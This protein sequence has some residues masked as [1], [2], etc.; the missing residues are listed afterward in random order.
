VSQILS[1]ERVVEEG[2]RLI[3]A[4][5]V[6]QAPRLMSA[7]VALC[8]H[9][10]SICSIAGIVFCLALSFACSTALAAEPKR[11]MMLHSFGPDVKPWSEYARA[12]RA[13]LAEQ[14]PWPLDLYEHS[15]VSAR[16]SDEDPEVPFV[17]Y[18]RALYAKRPLDLIVTIGA[19]AAAFVQRHRRQLFSTAPMVFTARTIVEA[20]AGKIW[21]ENQVGGGAIFRLQLPLAKA[22]SADA[23]P[24]ATA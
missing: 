17:E 23:T 13:E 8:L 16:F 22:P 5:S 14:S 19:P 10:R 4:D 21:A 20:H 24:P 6:A 9:I 15:L 12:I 7:I 2:Q 1:R 3:I 18:L 11:V